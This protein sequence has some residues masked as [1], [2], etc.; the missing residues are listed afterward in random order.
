MDDAVDVMAH[1][2][3]GKRHAAKITPPMRASAEW[4]YFQK[5]ETQSSTIG[6]P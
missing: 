2:P 3:R 1:K 6:Q 4:I 5:R